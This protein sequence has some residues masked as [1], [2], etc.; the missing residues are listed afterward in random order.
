MAYEA[1]VNIPL[2]AEQSKLSPLLKV[3]ISYKKYAG[4]F[5]ITHLK[6]LP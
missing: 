3:Y 5:V 2:C 4:S 6:P 1:I